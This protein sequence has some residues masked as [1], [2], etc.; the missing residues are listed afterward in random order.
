MN[1]INRSVG[2]LSSFANPDSGAVYRSRKILL[3]ILF[4]GLL[5]RVYIAFFSFLPHMYADSVGY[6]EQAT[7]LLTG[8]YTNYFPNGFPFI[9]ALLK[10]IGGA[11][12]VTLL[13]C[14]NVLLSTLSIYFLYSIGKKV[15]GLEIVALIAA[16]ILA[17][18]PSQINYVRWYTSEVPAAFLLLGAYFFYCAKKNWWSGLFFGFATAVRT[19]VLPILG[20]LMVLEIIWLKKFNIRLLAGAM[21]PL[22]L[23]AYYCHLKTGEFSISGHGRV[24]ILYAVTASGAC[25][26][27]EFVNKHP[28][29]NTTGKALRMYLDY[30]KAEPL[31]FIKNKLANLW[32]LWGFFPSS[33]GGTR[34][35]G[36]RILIG[37]SNFF[38]I[39]FG[40]TAWWKN[41]KNFMIFILI[42]PFLV[43][44]PIHSMLIGNPRYSYIEEPFM[45]LLAAWSLSQ[46]LI[47]VRPSPNLSKI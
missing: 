17:L 34:G 29:I 26:D 39:T 14:L 16:F 28:E 36:S 8:G 30:F 19:D 24:N 43:L 13:L 32:E 4:L 46:L 15:F 38:L 5:L 41:R 11:H 40:L 42:I 9:I 33:A 21:L 3:T 2:G 20:L 18:F 31:Q 7:I 27:W 1:F 23:V 25:V 6:F 22:L 44:T 47:L 35:I 45:I 37:L 12:A 10:A